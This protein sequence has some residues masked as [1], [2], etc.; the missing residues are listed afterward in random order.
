VYIFFSLLSRI[1]INCYY[2]YYYYYFHRLAAFEMLKFKKP[3]YLAYITK[4]SDSWLKFYRAVFSP[5]P[6]FV[7]LL[8]WTRSRGSAVSVVTGLRVEFDYRQGQQ[9]Y[10]LT[11]APRP[12]WDPTSLQLL[13][14]GYGGRVMNLTSH[15]YLVPS[16][17]MSGAVPPFFH[18]VSW[19][20]RGQ[21]YVWLNL[22]CGLRLLECV[23][24]WC[25]LFVRMLYNIHRHTRCDVLH[26]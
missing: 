25:I 18:V 12:V 3:H 19:H 7:L 8:F 24:L 4:S 1:W 5:R 15:L 21:R 14:T 20:S 17:R 16:W 2:Y 11:L 13:C 23:F 9:M 22:F 6:K 10:V 26:Y